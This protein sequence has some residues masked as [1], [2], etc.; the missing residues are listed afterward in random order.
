MNARSSASPWAADRFPGRWFVPTM[1]TQREVHYLHWLTHTWCEGAGRIVELGCFLGGSTMAL[2]TGLGANPRAVRPMLTYDAFEMDWFGASILQHPYKC[3]ERF[4]PLFDLYLKDHLHNIVVREGWIPHNLPREKEPELYPEQEPVEVLF[5]DA[6]KTWGVHL[7]ILRTFGRHLV[8]G[9]S[10]VAQQDFKNYYVHWIPLHMHQLRDCFEPVHD[11]PLSAT[12]SFRY[13]GGIEQHLDRLRRPADI[14]VCAIDDTWDEIEAYWEER[15]AHETLMTILLN[16]ATHFAN[17]KNFE[18]ALAAAKRFVERFPALAETGAGHPTMAAQEFERTMDMLDGVAGDDVDRRAAA[19]SLRAAAPK[20][21]RS[22]P[23]AGVTPVHQALW[24]Q[25]AIRCV[26]AGIHRIALYGAGDHTR[27]LLSSGWPEGRLEVTAIIDDAPRSPTLRSIPILRPKDLQ[28][29]I[30]AVIL[31]S[32][33]YEPRLREA[34]TRAFAERS[35][36][37]IAM[38]EPA[39]L[40]A[41]AV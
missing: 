15:S 28:T 33:S 20:L 7:S 35:I 38:Y 16:R 27:R 22:Q 17:Q 32:D 23:G 29:E 3:G 21:M 39:P 12:Y 8:P 10:I 34:A 1:L 36:P 6:A 5:I 24:R 4:R 40:A 2:A 26:E 19:A 11:V 25:V 41:T 14:P 9:K 30:D 13:L 31:S 37:I 18:G